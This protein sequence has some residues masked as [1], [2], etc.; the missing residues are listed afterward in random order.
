MGPWCSLAALEL[1]E[2]PFFKKKRP[3]KKELTLPKGKTGF[4]RASDPS[5]NTLFLK[6]RVGNLGGPITPF[7]W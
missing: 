4:G 1:R 7:Y 2:D 5:S 6:K 3:R